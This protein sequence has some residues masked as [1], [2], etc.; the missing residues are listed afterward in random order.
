MKG[1]FVNTPSSRD[2]FWRDIFNKPR[3]EEEKECEDMH[4]ELIDQDH[5]YK[6]VGKRDSDTKYVLYVSVAIEGK[7]YLIGTPVVDDPIFLA[8]GLMRAGKSILDKIEK[9]REINELK[10]SP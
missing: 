1:R 8:H 3:K 9:I 2:S 5:I 7:S 4:V 6:S 10:N